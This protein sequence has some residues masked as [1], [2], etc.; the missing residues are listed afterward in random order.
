[1][2]RG[3]L[4]LFALGHA[5]CGKRGEH[6]DT[7]SISCRIV[8]RLHATDSQGKAPGLLAVS[9]HECGMLLLHLAENAFVVIRSH[10]ASIKCVCDVV[11]GIAGLLHHFLAEAKGRTEYASTGN[12]VGA[13]GYVSILLSQRAFLTP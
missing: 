3:T 1:M 4:A 7:V 13:P 6:V 8:K 9:D 5:E 11:Y 2:G 12:S 10:V